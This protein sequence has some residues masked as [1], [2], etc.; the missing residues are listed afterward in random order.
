[1]LRLSTAR[2]ATSYP[3]SL[4]AASVGAAAV[5]TGSATLCERQRH[6]ASGAAPGH[7]VACS[8]ARKQAFRAPKIGGTVDASGLFC[9]GLWCVV[10]IAAAENRSQCIEQ[11]LNP[12]GRL[13]APCLF[14][15]LLEASLGRAFALAW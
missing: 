11:C 5:W 7:A 9:C 8:G 1:M 10:G 6:Q 15:V 12:G 2:A 3:E 14:V 4:P 13:F